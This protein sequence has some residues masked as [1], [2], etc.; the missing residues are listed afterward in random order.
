MLLK[1]VK[2]NG[3]RKLRS[4]I[5]LSTIPK[6]NVTVSK[7]KAPHRSDPLRDHLVEFKLDKR[8]FIPIRFVKV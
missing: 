5:I 2:N 6:N 1:I 7:M 3:P 4:I 8:R